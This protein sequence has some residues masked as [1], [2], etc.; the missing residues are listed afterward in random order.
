[1]AWTRAYNQ[2]TWIYIDQV[3][4][5]FL[6]VAENLDSCPL[7]NLLLCQFL[8]KTGQLGPFYKVLVDC[9]VPSQYVKT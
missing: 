1:M 6:I 7:E 3:L 4:E 8:P 5:R 2:L 9:R